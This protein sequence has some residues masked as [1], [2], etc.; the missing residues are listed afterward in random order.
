MLIIQ[1]ANDGES[2]QNCSSSA[3]QTG[4]LFTLH[5]NFTR[6]N[7]LTELFCVGVKNWVKE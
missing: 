4:S 3:D 7:F 2:S 1:C 5:I 6:V